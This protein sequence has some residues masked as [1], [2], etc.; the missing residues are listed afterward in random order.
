MSS[1]KKPI[2]LGNAIA[3]SNI[4]YGLLK[5][6]GLKGIKVAGSIRRQE[7]IVG[8]ID[9]M[10]IGDITKVENCPEFEMVQCGTKSVT[11]LYE[12]IQVNLYA[13]EPGYYGS[14]LMFLTG[15]GKYNIALRVY[16]KK[17]GFKISQYGIFDRNTNKL[18]HSKTE[19][20]IYKVL[21]KSYK[22]PE[23]RGWKDKK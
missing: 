17:R 5:R 23:V 18:L 8:D 19:E 21:G 3:A 12:G 2:E 1:Q 20:G 10:A 9:M 16:A 4:I 11:F 13:Y 7:E 6:C 15:P 22:D 14:M